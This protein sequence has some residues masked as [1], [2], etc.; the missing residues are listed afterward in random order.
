[1]PS[2]FKHG[3]DHAY[4]TNKNKLNVPG[5]RK[6]K[7]PQ[8]LAEKMFG[9]LLN[10]DALNHIFPEIFEKAIGER[11]L[12]P[13]GRPSAS[14]VRT[15]DGG[16]TVTVT[17]TLKPETSIS[18]YKGIKYRKS[19]VSVSDEEVD[20]E[21]NRTREKNAR[22][23]EITDR[24]IQDGDVAVLDFEGFVDGVAFEGGK[25]EDFRLVIGSKTFIDTFEEQL[26]GLN[27]GDEKDV[28]VNF[29]ENYHK[30]D[31]SGKPAVF[32]VK[33][34]NI[35]FREL[36]ELDNDFAQ[37]VSEFETF[38]AYKADIQEKIQKAK[39]SDALNM[40]TNEVL[41]KLVEKLD[42]DVPSTMIEEELNASLNNFVNQLRAQGID[43]QSYLAYTGQTTN[44]FMAQQK[45]NA[46]N[47]VFGRLALE[48]VAAAEGMTV[49]Q[50]EF[51]KELD[52][53][54]EAY[55][56]EK[57]KLLTSMSAHEKYSMDTDILVRKALD[58]VLENA[59]AEVEEEVL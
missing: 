41:S 31:L 15:D 12:H 52:S 21:I 27:A 20:R 22:E 2:V 44:S 40:K 7:T 5:F 55:K 42:A 48:A 14:I 38:D 25:S 29:P 36:P 47:S 34:K 32:K 6:G 43:V 28:N 58:F 53:L 50:E 1:E 16:A 45:I 11:Q 49:S 9:D 8:K 10:E 57:D 46:R 18:D 39:E 30:D 59:E 23:T 51:D 24:P 54:A 37:D 4:K 17:V 19:E 33:I 13:V 35:Y 3:L 26:I 56:L